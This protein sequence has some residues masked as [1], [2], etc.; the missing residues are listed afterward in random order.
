MRALRWILIIV[1]LTLAYAVS[2]QVTE[3]DFLKL[4]TAAPKAQQILSRLLSPELLVNETTTSTVSL[5]FPV[6]CG[7][8]PNEA[9]AGTPKLVLS[10]PCAE[11]RAMFKVSGTGIRPESEVTLR[12]RL[13]S[14][15][16]LSVGRV[17]ADASGRYE[18]EL[19]ARPIAVTVN[20]VPA[21][22]EA[23]I[24][25]VS[26]GLVVSK[27]LRDVV[28]AMFVTVFIALV[29]TTIA[30]LI[31]APLAF[32]A[33]R[34]I[35]GTGKA[36]TAVYYAMRAVFNV[37]R[38]FEVLVLATIFAL[39][40][41]F[42]SPFAGVLALIVGTVASLGKM[43]SESI[44]G[45]DPGPV[46]AITATGANRLQQARFGIVPQIVPDFLSFIIYHWDINVRIST[47]IGFVGGGGVGYYLAQRIN[48][49]EYSKAGTALLIVILV[50]WALDVFSTQV[51]KR[52]T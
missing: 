45:I 16:P 6:P 2:I 36:G 22:L 48:T 39:I 41:G 20:G 38:A 46:E 32:F 47:I 44:E 49:L 52:L 33:A 15:N 34:N 1:G 27:T 30:T 21:Q 17:S 19:Q 9:G 14:G 50:V 7:S 8:A 40:V 31:A 28:D 24:E 4:V 10:A 13:P 5:A 37:T 35:T 26:G 23:E 3:P 12:W 11:E 25:E 29:A 43:F 42:G 18:T 51:R